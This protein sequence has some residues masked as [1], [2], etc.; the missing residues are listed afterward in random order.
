[1]M[2]RTEAAGEGWVQMSLQGRP[3]GG[4]C[5]L[6]KTECPVAAPMDCELKPEVTRLGMPNLP[7][8]YAR[9]GHAG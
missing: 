5:P 9:T 8:S 4:I 3:P 2:R 1:M 6:V 7:P